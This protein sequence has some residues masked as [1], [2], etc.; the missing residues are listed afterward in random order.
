MNVTN[1][2]FFSIVIPLYNKENYIKETLQSVIQQSFTDFEVII[3]NDGSTDRSVLF[4]QKINDPRIKIIEQENGGVSKARNTGIQ[5]ATSEYIAFL[6]ADDLWKSNFL[7]EIHCL[8][9]ENPNAS[10]FGTAY[11]LQKENGNERSINIKGLPKNFKKGMVPCF[12]KVMASGDNFVW[13][14]AICIRKRV[15]LEKNI[16]FPVGEKYG[17]DQYVWATVAIGHQV[18]YSI[19]ECAIY[20]IE[21]E[22]NTVKDT[23]NAMEP[24]GSFFMI[25]GLRNTISEQKLLEGFDSYCSKLFY[26]F[27]LKNMLYGVKKRGFEQLVSYKLSSKHKIK[28]LIAFLLPRYFTHLFIKIKYGKVDV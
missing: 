14:S 24:H 18:A 28:L 22:N 10:L 11:V 17:E 3:V 21:A 20:K 23:N 16:W 9:I 26:S 19:K 15:F 13:T 27:A 6:D 5:S 1:K 7:E 12:F 4:A 2:P 8:I 25:R